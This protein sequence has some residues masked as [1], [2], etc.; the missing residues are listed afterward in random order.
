MNTTT[1]RV[2]KLL[3]GQSTRETDDSSGAE[4]STDD[5]PT[6]MSRDDLKAAVK[7]GVTEALD[8]R[9]ASSETDD[10]SA[11][12]SSSGSS[13]LRKAGSLLATLGAIGAI[14]YLRRRR[15]TGTT[16]EEDT[17][18]QTLEDQR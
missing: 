14:A 15:T 12:E 11:E 13:R 8:E 10:E 16:D 3:N 6:T 9:E 17:H 2:A 5:E 7:E 4:A 1:E 18:T